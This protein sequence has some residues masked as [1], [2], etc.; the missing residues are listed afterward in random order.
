M[1]ENTLD[2]LEALEVIDPAALSYQEWLSVGMGLK[3]AGYPVSA[4]EAWSRRDPARFHNGECERKWRSFTGSADPVTAGTIV[5]MARSRG[6]QTARSGYGALEQ[7]GREMGWN[8]WIHL[9]ADGPKGVVDRNWLEPREIAEPQ[10]WDPVKDL[11]RYLE[12]LFSPDDRVGYVTRS[13]EKD[14]KRFPSTG[15]RKSTRL[16]SSHS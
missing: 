15:D 7:H 9:D 16:N 11:I 6:W 10:Q 2:L 8:D 1:T 3:E 12:I 4:W 14:G 13:F 5:Q